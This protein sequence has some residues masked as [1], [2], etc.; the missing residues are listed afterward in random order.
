VCRVG[1]ERKTLG[2][3]L[4]AGNIGAEIDVI[5]PALPA[6]THAPI[7]IH[8]AFGVSPTSFSSRGAVNMKD[9]PLLQK[10]IKETHGCDSR[11]VE[12]VPVHEVFKGQTA[13]QGTVAVF[14]LI[15][16]PTAK[17][18]YAWQY[19]DGFEMKSVAVLEIP[20]VYS[21]QTAVKV[22]IVSKG[23]RQWPNGQ[24]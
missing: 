8:F 6:Q 24:K 23:R 16:H 5:K 19:R 22:A 7:A 4:N 20:P 13:W 14:D 9:I 10:A 21:P 11:Y 12:S 18:C 1:P 3:G 15:R 17:R 2:S